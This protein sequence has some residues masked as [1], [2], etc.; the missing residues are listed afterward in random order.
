MTQLF[1][2]R[3][4]MYA[5]SVKTLAV[6][7]QV[8]FRSSDAVECLTLVVF[9]AATMLSGRAILSEPKREL[10]SRRPHRMLLLRGVTPL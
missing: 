8:F 6:A 10:P 5:R 9:D 3:Y 2:L 4:D 1:I 7:A